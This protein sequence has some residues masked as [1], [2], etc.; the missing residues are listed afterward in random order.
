[1]IFMKKIAC[2]ALFAS[3]ASVY[4]LNSYADKTV[5]ISTGEYSPWVSKKLKHLGYVSHIVNEAFKREGYT[6]EFKFFPWKRAYESAKKGEF[7]ATSFWFKS[8]DR[9]KDFYYSDPVSTE[10]TVFFHLKTNPLADWNTVADLKDKTIGA[11]T[12]Y[13]YT[14]EFWEAGENGTIK[15]STASSDDK[16][17]KKLLASRVDLFPMGTV[18]GYGLLAD[19]FDET[20]L[21][22]I[23]FHPKPLVESTGHLLFSKQKADNEELLKIFN[24]GLKKLKDEGLDQK[25]REDLMAGGYKK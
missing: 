3:I 15:I 5:T 18:A 2:Y 1:M 7:H 12:G 24:A 23:T 10:K 9:E 19:K 4:S 8:P 6:V 22:L 20:S 16:N 11:T 25:W 14:K 13:T 21:H 17:F